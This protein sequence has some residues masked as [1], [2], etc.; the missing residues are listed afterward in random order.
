MVT[1]PEVS[2]VKDNTFSSRYKASH[3]LGQGGFGCVFAGV[4]LCDGLPVAI[5]QVPKCSVTAWGFMNGVRVPLEF[6]LLH[7]VSHIPGVV[8]LVGGHDT[9]NVFFIIMERIESCKDLYVFIKERGALSEVTAR[10]FFRQVVH[11]VS[12][13]HLAG[14]LHRDI[15]NE[16]IIVDLESLTLKLIDF[17]AGAYVE[18]TLDKNF[19][20]TRLYCPPEW[21]QHKKYDGIPAMMW[22]LGVLLYHMVCGHVPFHTNEEITSAQVRFQKEH[23]VSFQCQHLILILL[24]FHCQDRPSM[25]QVL[26]HPWLCPA[27]ETDIS[28]T[29]ISIDLIDSFLETSTSMDFVDYISAIEAVAYCNE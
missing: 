16:N 8:K 22:S 18:E 28:A 19:F 1:A 21:I 10:S 23:S 20:G 11:T 5:K 15:K 4:R 25:E 6:C 13:C 3:V 7:R 12:D 29:H 27:D 9:D 26:S 2:L 14:V 17:G 24:Q